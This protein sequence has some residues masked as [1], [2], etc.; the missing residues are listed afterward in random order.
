MSGVIADNN[1]CGCTTG[2]GALVKTGTGTLTLSGD[3]TYS[4]GTTIN[5]GAL[6]LGNGG[7]TGSILGDVAV[8]TGAL[9]AINHSDTFTFSGVISGG[10]AFQKLG[11]GTTIL[12]ATNSYTGGT[13]ITA[14]TLQLGDAS[15]TGKIVGDISNISGGIFDIVKADTT[16]V[17]SITNGNGGTTN[18][19]NAIAPARDHPQQQ[20]RL[21]I[22]LRHRH[23]RHRTPDRQC[24]RQ[25]RHV[26]PDHERHVGRLDR[27][28]RLALPR[29][30]AVH[31]R[32]TI[33]R[34]CS[35]A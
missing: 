18:F 2:P 14:G 32:Q 6:M 17:S 30:E 25:D 27:G 15:N 9:F 34:P 29:L 22:L 3:N 16:G 7:A 12:T 33:S 26:R 31:R 13:T 5:A 23:R 35:T 28:R 1:P 21:D 10:G 4:G 19:R 8:N 20:R 11:T 24:R